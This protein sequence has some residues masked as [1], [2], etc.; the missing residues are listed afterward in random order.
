MGPLGGLR[1]LEFAGIGAGPHCAMML[2]D[3]GA[4]VVR[5]D[6]LTS[7]GLGMEVAP[8][9]DIL[10]RGRRS[11]AIDLK[12]SEG[13]EVALGLLARADASIESFRPGVMER[14]GLGPEIC[15]RVNP[16]IVYARLTGWGQSGPYSHAAGHDI[17]YIAL[18]GALHGIGPAEGPPQPP[19]N[20]LGDFGGGALHC[21]VGMLGALLHAQRT[22]EGQVVDAAMVD[23]VTAMM[24]LVVSWRRAGLWTLERGDNFVDGGAPYYSTYRTSDGLYVAV[25]AMEEKFYN[26]LL[27][28][29]GISGIPHMRPHTDRKLW[30]EQRKIFQATFARQTRREWCDLLEGTDACFAPVLT[31]DEA[32]E[33]P[34]IQARGMYVDLNGVAHPA[35]A[36][37]LS[38]T[39]A[40][41]RSSS[42]CVGEHTSEV[43][44]EWGWDRTHLSRLLDSGAIIQAPAI[45]STEWERANATS[46]AETATDRSRSKPDHRRG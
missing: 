41:I 15:L 13:R 5:V 8:E 1:V 23:G 4:D 26:L 14:L 19:M 36:P 33:H 45:A 18:A 9:F 37:K 11:V 20:L 30:P 22:G 2:A 3:M 10:G 31:M 43:L 39:P 21:V 25:G 24:G 16:R 46:L 34:H 6:R 27:D 40:R 44:S 35:P 28:K 32:A 38:R 12:K 7:S 17:N 29:L 42:P